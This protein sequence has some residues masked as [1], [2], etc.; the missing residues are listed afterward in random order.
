MA[1]LF[2]GL[3]GGGKVTIGSLP[4]MPNVA[5]YKRKGGDLFLKINERYH[6]R[7]KRSEDGRAWQGAGVAEKFDPNEKVKV[8]QQ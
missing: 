3:F 5:V 6:V 4:Q 7:A 8:V 1:N 2:A